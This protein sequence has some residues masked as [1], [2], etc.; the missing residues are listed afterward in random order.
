MD[1]WPQTSK[2]IVSIWINL[3]RLSAGKKSTST[4]TFTWRYCKDI[5]FMSFRA[6][7]AYLV[8]HTQSS[9]IKWYYS[10]QAKNQLHPSCCS[11][12]IA[13]IWKLILCIFGKLG[14]THLKWKYQL[15][16][17]FDVYLHGKNIFHHSLLFWDTKF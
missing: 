9:T 8:R 1:A 10:L 6:F 13:K 17:D 12:C 2:I 16:E 14:Y 5:A 11:R 15:V 7:G 3:Q 4:L